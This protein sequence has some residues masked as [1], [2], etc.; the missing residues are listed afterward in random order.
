V[1]DVI[2]YGMNSPNVDF[3]V[4]YEWVQHS[5]PEANYSWVKARLRCANRS[6]ATTGSQFNVS[7][8]HRVW[9]NTGQ[10]WTHNANPFLPSGYGPG[11]ALA[12]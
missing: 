12:R 5:S 3:W 7:G 1:V 9:N 4:E 6:N 10:Q 11:A 8:Y 2:Y